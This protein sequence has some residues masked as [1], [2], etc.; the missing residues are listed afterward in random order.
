MFQF[1][2][3]FNGIITDCEVT[4]SYLPTHHA[5]ANAK[6]AAPGCSTSKSEILK[7]NS[8]NTGYSLTYSINIY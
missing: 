2:A 7:C 4:S 8:R 5:R 6:Q 1:S 3:A